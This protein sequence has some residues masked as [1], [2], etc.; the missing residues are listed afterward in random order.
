[1]PQENT[2]SQKEPKPKSTPANKAPKLP[3]W[4]QKLIGGFPCDEELSQLSRRRDEAIAALVENLPYAGKERAKWLEIL[5]LLEHAPSREMWFH[6]IRTSDSIHQEALFKYHVIADHEAFAPRSAD[7]KAAYLEIANGSNL[8]IVARVILNAE[9]DG[10]IREAA[11]ARLDGTS[12][13]EK[14]DAYLASVLLLNAASDEENTRILAWLT[15]TYVNAA[16]FLEA[17]SESVLCKL[18]RAGG[19]TREP[20]EAF[21]HKLLGEN[22]A[23]ILA[24]TELLM[25]FCQGATSEVSAPTLEKIVRRKKSDNPTGEA[26]LGLGK[27]RGPSV[28]SMFEEHLPDYQMLHYMVD[29]LGW[30]AARGHQ[31]AADGFMLKHFSTFGHYAAV[32]A[33]R[34]GGAKLVEYAM[35]RVTEF[36]AEYAT[37]LRRRATGQTQAQFY[38]RL[39]RDGLIPKLTEIANTQA[40]ERSGKSWTP[41]EA[42]IKAG[43][44]FTFDGESDLVPPPYAKLLER[45][46]DFTKG[47]FAPVDLQQNDGS[48]RV[49][50]RISDQVF[51]IRP[52]DLGDFY[53]IEAVFS[54]VNKALAHCRS[55]RR[56]LF[57]DTDDQ[58]L[59]V[60]F[61]E[62]EPW[63]L[64][65]S[66]FGISFVLYP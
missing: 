65:G 1:M 22:E 53:D 59:A 26:L 49:S 21:F 15:R 64:A 56:F 38:E 44:A 55:T 7:E 52:E 47:E 36:R 31:D 5:V 32:Y 28:F 29:C 40:S 63:K 46:A 37:P 13:A 48:R 61:G 30:L 39:L 23:G 16:N 66:E 19:K 12:A 60:V 24:A 58:T 51:T 27:I 33:T 41:L 43:V 11:F 34:H 54:T 45:L 14:G 35:S 57:L 6:E 42:L 17:E 10:E 62:P 50:F 4:V 20:A 2:E 8:D 18:L 25:G 3:A 9:G